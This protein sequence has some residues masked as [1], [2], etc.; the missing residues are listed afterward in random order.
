MEIGVISTETESSMIIVPIV[1]IAVECPRLLQGVGHTCLGHM[2][3]NVLTVSEEVFQS[4]PRSQALMRDL[5]SCRAWS[6]ESELP[7]GP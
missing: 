1:M 4:T 3:T 7:R 6:T 2:K 5:F